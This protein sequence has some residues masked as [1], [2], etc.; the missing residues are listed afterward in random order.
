MPTQNAD[1]LIALARWLGEPARDLVALGEG[2]ASVTTGARRFLVTASGAELGGV[3][4]S[5]VVELDLAKMLAAI[6]G[7]GELPT[8]DPNGPRASV[9]AP[10]H[11]VCLL[12][13]GVR[14][15][16]HTH[17]TAIN[18]L[19]CSALFEQALAG[20]LFHDEVVVCGPQPLLL[21]YV[22]SGLPLARALRQPLA[23]YTARHG[24]PPRTIYLQNHGFVALGGSR[25]EVQAITTMAVKAARV[26]LGA[27]T[28]GGI[29]RLSDEAAQRIAASPEK[30]YEYRSLQAGKE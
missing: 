19:T 29:H 25:Q 9:E 26:R 16:G 7:D 5:R 21:P 13:P 30:R 11:A 28:L 10:M 2:N 1:E 24:Q 22:D 20:R 12:L 14:C 6:D 23:D 8:D 3:D 27:A 17:P 15:V 18:A 4:A